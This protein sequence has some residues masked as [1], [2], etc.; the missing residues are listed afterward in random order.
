MHTRAESGQSYY[1]GDKPAEI[2][3]PP[4]WKS[5]V[6]LGCFGARLTESFSDDV[7]TKQE[8]KE[9]GEAAAAPAM[10]KS[11]A[12]KEAGD[13]KQ[14]GDEGKEAGV[15]PDGSGGWVD[16]TNGMLRNLSGPIRG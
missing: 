12:N 14:A 6:T 15:M 1:E 16:C 4:V 7:I 13:E 2:V 9:S 5:H 10:G 3:P 11:K 8:G